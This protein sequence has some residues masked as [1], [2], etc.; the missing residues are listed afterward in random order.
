ML[1]S[2]GCC[3]SM[4]RMKAVWFL[5]LLASR[6]LWLTASSSAPRVASTW[7]SC[8][9][10]RKA[11]ARLLLLRLGDHRHI[12]FNSHL[13]SRSLAGISLC[14]IVAS[15]HHRVWQKWGNCIHLYRT[16]SGKWACSKCP[17]SMYLR[18][19]ILITCLTQCPC[20]QASSYVSTALQWHC[21]QYYLVK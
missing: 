21:I 16:F 19:P 18:G 14:V 15:C 17:E 3:D 6:C 20:H 2:S 13:C 1:A 5:R 12:T 8:T 10:S 11:V 4:Q 9:I 7:V